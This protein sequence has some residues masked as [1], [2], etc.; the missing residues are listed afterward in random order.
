MNKITQKILDELENNIEDF[1][2]IKEK[3]W[4]IEFD[5]YDTEKKEAYFNALW[6]DN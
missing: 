2:I 3:Y 1:Y 5:D 4:I 6:Y